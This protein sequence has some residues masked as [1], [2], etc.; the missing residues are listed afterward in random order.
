M[1]KNEFEGI[2]CKMFQ[3]PVCQHVDGLEQNYSNSTTEELPVLH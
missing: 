1:F 2:V 3:A